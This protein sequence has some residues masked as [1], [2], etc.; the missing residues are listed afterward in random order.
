MTKAPRIQLLV[1]RILLSVRYRTM[2]IYIP[3]ATE[4]PEITTGYLQICCVRV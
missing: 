3:I 1:D 4:G 2:N